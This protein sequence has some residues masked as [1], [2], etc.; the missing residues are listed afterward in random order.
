MARNG[1]Q[2]RW[3]RWHSDDWTA[4]VVLTS[5]GEFQY[6]AW[7]GAHEDAMKTAPSR[8]A[9]QHAAEDIVRKSGHRCTARCSF[10]VAD[11]PE[12]LG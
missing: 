6:T 9:A 5:A 4:M 10:W 11:T 8:V 12:D 2:N 7:Q 3:T 1:I